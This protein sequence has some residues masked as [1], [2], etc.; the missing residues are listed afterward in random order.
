[1]R[2]MHRRRYALL[3]E[4]TGNE[5]SLFPFLSIFLCV[6]GVL[7]FLNL[8]NSAIAPSKVML[9]GD[10]AQG[11]K[12]AYQILC[13][14]EGMVTVPPLKRLPELQQAPGGQA[15]ELVQLMQQ[16]QAQRTKLA[17]KLENLASVATEPED[18][19][20]LPL[21]QEID[22]INRLARERKILYEEFILFGI[23]PDG[24][25]VYHKIRA[26]LLKHPELG[27]GVGMEPLNT[28]WRLSLAEE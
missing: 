10:V 8:I 6:M 21:L 12:T 16:R 4:T 2:A 1:M 13:L 18:E 26:V 24:G 5:V 9:V 17:E 22:K 27:I 15:G 7:S 23:Y 19:A 3:L 14:P 11:Y 25:S 20:V 28:N